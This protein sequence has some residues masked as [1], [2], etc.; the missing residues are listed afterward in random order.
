MN[1]KQVQA[2]LQHNK[3]NL[4][5][6]SAKLGITPQTLNSRFKASHFKSSYLLAINNAIGRDLFVLSPQ[7]DTL[8]HVITLAAACPG[9]PLESPQNPILTTLSVPSFKG[10]I[11]F[12][13]NSPEMQP[14]YLCGDTVFVRPIAN[15]SVID[16]GKDYLIITPTDFLLRT[17]QP[18]PRGDTH[19][20]LCVRN[21][22]TQNNTPLYPDIDL[23]RT[24]I[25]H[26]YKVVGILS[27]FG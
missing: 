24:H 15:T 12:V 5:W 23:N 11:A 26:L 6:L 17:L 22:I 7:A 3:I 2:I 4:R 10:C 13:C 1:G 14:R 25:T 27:Y 21:H 20:R 19:I 9:L 16:Y 8:Q 18:S